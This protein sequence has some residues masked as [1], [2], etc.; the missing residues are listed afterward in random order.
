MKKL[1]LLIAML[2]GIAALAGDGGFLFVTFKGEQT[3]MSEQIYF[4]VSHD[5]RQWNELNNAQPVLVS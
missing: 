5:G 4:V 1:F 3:P 2:T